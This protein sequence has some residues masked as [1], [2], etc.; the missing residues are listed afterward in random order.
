[1]SYRLLVV[2]AHSAPREASV[3]AALAEAQGFS[4]Q[5]LSWD[6][7][8]PEALASR[9]PDALLAVAVP[10]TPR[11]TQVLEW[12][13]DNPIRTP[14]LVVLPAHPPDLLMGLGAQVSDDFILSP[15]R[16]AE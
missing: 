7:A 5:Q 14:T 1:M 11:V 8:G 6:A 9:G 15:V 10:H 12:L 3:Q 13:R 2:E 16:A 4:V